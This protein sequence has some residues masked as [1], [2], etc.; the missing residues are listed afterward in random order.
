MKFFYYIFSIIVFCIASFCIISPS[1]MIDSAKSGILLWSNIVLPSLFPFLILSD[2]IQKSAITK[3]FEKLLSKIIKPLFNLPGISSLAIFLGMTG[4]YPIGAKITSDLRN[5]NSLSKIESKRLIAF[6]NNSGPMFISG[7]IGIGLYKNASI[8]FLL[9]ISH[10]LSSFLVGILF[11]F[12]KK[13]KANDTH[14]SN[15]EFNIIKLSSL[16]ETLTNTVKKAIS[17]VTVIGG[18]IVLFSIITTILEKTGLLLFI[19]KFL[20]P[21]LNTDLSSSIISGILEVTNGVNR[22]FQL[23]STDL[24]LK[25]IITSALIGFGG[26][27]VHMQTLSVISNSDI[28]SSTYFLGKSMQSIFSAIFT[29]LLLN[30]TNFSSLIFQPTFATENYTSSGFIKFISTII[31]IFLLIVVFKI[32]QLFLENNTK[33]M[34]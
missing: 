23:D 9:L 21:N 15:I 5:D 22:I 11:R 12:Y 32:L 33:K 27:S 16:G 25:L 10:Y 18:F 4:G 3:V 17:T 7:A 6:A 20:M 2:L 26:F 31:I 30:Y 13:E 14:K 19:S 24:T 29:F 28:G 34:P 8:G 1:E